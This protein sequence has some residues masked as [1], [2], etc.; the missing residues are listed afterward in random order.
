MVVL[1]DHAYLGMEAEQDTVASTTMTTTIPL[2][3]IHHEP[4]DRSRHEVH[5]AA[6]QAATHGNRAF[7]PVQRPAQLQ[8]MLRIS[9]LIATTGL[10]NNHRHKPDLPT[11]L[12]VEEGNSN[13]LHPSQSRQ[14]GSAEVAEVR[15]SGPVLQAPHQRLVRVVTSLPDLEVQDGVEQ[16][17]VLGPM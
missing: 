2:H 16:S 14:V 1:D 4:Q 7:G 3:R 17:A 13:T 5:Q 15:A 12:E 10:N 11:G 6:A 8:L 9:G